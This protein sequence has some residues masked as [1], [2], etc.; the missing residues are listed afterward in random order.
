MMFVC[1]SLDSFSDDQLL[2]E[3]RR[4]AA[5][6]RAATANLLARRLKAPNQALPGQFPRSR[7]PA[8]SR[9]RACRRHEEL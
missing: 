9:R 6:E 2:A 7:L 4:L 3:L 8:Q 5:C 1:P